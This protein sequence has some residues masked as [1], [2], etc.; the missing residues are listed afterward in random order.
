MRTYVHGGGTSLYQKKG[1]QA[2]TCSPNGEGV[3]P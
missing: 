1:G 2:L 3:T